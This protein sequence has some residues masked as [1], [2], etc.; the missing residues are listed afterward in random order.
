MAVV[1]DETELSLS[2]VDR[3][4]EMCKDIE[5][6]SKSNETLATVLYNHVMNYRVT[7]LWGPYDDLVER[8]VAWYKLFGSFNPSKKEHIKQ[9]CRMLV[10]KGL[11]KIAT[12]EEPSEEFFTGV[13][14]GDISIIP[15]DIKEYIAKIV[16]QDNLKYLTILSE[17]NKDWKLVT[18]NARNLEKVY[19]TILSNLLTYCGNS[20]YSIYES[21]TIPA[22]QDSVVSD[23]EGKLATISLTEF[24]AGLADDHLKFYLTVLEKMI[25]KTNLEIF[26]E[27]RL[28]HEKGIF[29][30]LVIDRM[31]DK[32][33][34]LLVTPQK[35]IDA[36]VSTCDEYS[37]CIRVS[38]MELYTGSIKGLSTK[39]LNG[40]LHEKFP[41]ELV[42][43]Y[44]R[45]SSSSLFLID[46]KQMRNYIKRNLDKIS[47]SFWA[48]EKGFE[49]L[50]KYNDNKL[51]NIISEHPE[52]VITKVATK[53]QIPGILYDLTPGVPMN[54]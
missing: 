24:K 25:G 11:M 22:M 49:Q 32:E 52:N 37:L 6:V 21:S 35:M 33:R 42:N 23:V 8:Q 53:D 26:L 39:Y 30:N 13:A 44:K 48:R 40:H 10:R 18:K 31:Y 45:K 36:L 51:S 1:I 5:N 17:V 20:E 14:N 54:K 43:T 7:D 38:K 28:L 3:A 46:L 16:A 29:S 27:K 47:Q 4:R 41:K 12:Q 2:L 50:K 19:R 15:M 34:K 9:V